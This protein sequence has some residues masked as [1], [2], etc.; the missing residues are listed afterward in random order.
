MRGFATLTRPC[1]PRQVPLDALVRMAR[2]PDPAGRWRRAQT[3][4]IDEVSMLDGALFDALEAVARAVRGNDAP[5]G[6]VQLVCCGTVTRTATLCS[7][8]M[9]HDSH[10]CLPC[11]RLAWACTDSTR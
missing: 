2:R 6:G 11:A 1:Y 3:L 5:F 4:V 10:S 7:P 9:S 8:A